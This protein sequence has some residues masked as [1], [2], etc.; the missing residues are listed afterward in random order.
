MYLPPRRGLALTVIGPILLVVLVPSEL[1]I[2]FWRGVVASN[3]QLDPYSWLHIGQTVQID[4]GESQSIVAL[5]NDDAYSADCTVAGPSGEVEVYPVSYDDGGIGASSYLEVAQFDPDEAGAYRVDCAIGRVK[6]MPIQV[7][8]NADDAFGLRFV[9]GLAAA[10]LAFA[11]GVTLLI[12]G[13]VK[14]IH[15]S[16]ERQR[17]R[18]AQGGYGYLP[19]YGPP[20]GAPPPA[21]QFRY[22]HQPPTMGDPNDPYATPPEKR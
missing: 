11:I 5:D 7:L 1:A 20:Y 9:V 21:Y 4:G 14:L 6:V 19:Q 8:S 13:I 2:G 18:I 3:Q 12:V 22:A 16:Q 10:A 15:S 17:A